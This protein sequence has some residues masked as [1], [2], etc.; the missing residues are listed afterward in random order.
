MSLGNQASAVL[1]FALVVFWHCFGKLFGVSKQALN[2]L[3]WKI[4]AIRCGHLKCIKDYC[5]L[6][7]SRVSKPV[8]ML[9]VLLQL[10]LLF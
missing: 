10:S 9:H 6:P 2:K 7:I 8:A 4:V 1:L 3:V 5:T